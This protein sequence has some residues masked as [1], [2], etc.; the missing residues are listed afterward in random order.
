MVAIPVAHHF[1]KDDCHLLL[2]D[3]V[4][5]GEHISLGVLIIDRGIDALDGTSQHPQHLILVLQIRYHIGGVDARKRLVMG[6]LE[7]RRRP[8]RDRAPCGLEE[9]EEVGYQR[10]GQLSPHEVVQDF[11][12]AGI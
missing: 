12:I 11:L 5:R 1:L 4:L 10:V 2:V 8:H 9:G 7:Q 6:I 3:D